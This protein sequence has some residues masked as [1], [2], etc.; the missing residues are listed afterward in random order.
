METLVIITNGIRKEFM[1]NVNS[2]GV[3]MVINDIL[4][5]YPIDDWY[6]VKGWGTITLNVSLKDLLN[7]K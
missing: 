7:L 1:L 4:D 6:V 5:N 3:E 2:K